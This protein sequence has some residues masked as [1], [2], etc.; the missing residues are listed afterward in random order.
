MAVVGGL[1]GPERTFAVLIVQGLI[2]PEFAGVD[3]GQAE[4][5]AVRA[6][7]TATGAGP[8]QMLTVTA[9]GRPA[10]RLRS[11]WARCTGSPDRRVRGAGFAG[12]QAGPAGRP[13]SVRAEQMIGARS[14]ASATP[15]PGSRS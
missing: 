14:S 15:L 12:P 6:V 7:A 11:W 3:L 13:P 2:A 5:L 9:V 10:W 8:G 1:D 4:K